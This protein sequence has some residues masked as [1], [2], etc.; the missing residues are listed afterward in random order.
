MP[1]DELFLNPF[2]EDELDGQDT[3]YRTYR[4]DTKNHRI[5]GMIDGAD[6]CR[7]AVYKILQTRRFAHLIYDDQY[8][9]DIFNRIGQIGLTEEY[10]ETDIPAMVEDALLYEETVTGI[11]DLTFTI[12]DHDSVKVDFDISTI[13]GPIDMEG[14]IGNG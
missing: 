2:E 12:M 10:F 7:Q 1:E 3:I 8:G 4:M 14:V 6:A 13:Y 9:C 5:I 11:G